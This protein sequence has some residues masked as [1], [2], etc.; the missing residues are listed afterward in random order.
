MLSSQ[1][2]NSNSKQYSTFHFTLILLFIIVIEFHIGQE[3]SFVT[4][5]QME[6][7]QFSYLFLSL[8]IFT[9]NSR[10]P[11]SSIIITL[12]QTD[13]E[14]S[15]FCKS[16]APVNF[17]ATITSLSVFRSKSLLY[18]ALILIYMFFFPLYFATPISDFF[19]YLSLVCSMLSVI[20]QIYCV[21]CRFEVSAI[22]ARFV[23][24]GACYAFLSYLF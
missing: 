16:L 2:S 13:S 12:H 8:Q 11:Y 17:L 20:S 21:I 1:S 24:L 18:C 10:K 23:F 22:S 5:C 7:P 15:F 9:A 6:G 14:R 3:I 19:F 4:I